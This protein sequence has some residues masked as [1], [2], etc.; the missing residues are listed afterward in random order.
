[1]HIEFDSSEYRDL[2]DILHLADV[3]MT[4][5][6]KGDD[7]RTARH[8]ALIQKL[9]AQAKNA[10]LD[11]LMTFNKDLGTYVPTHDF[12]HT[13]LAHAVLD[14]FANHLFWDHL[15][16]RLT[17]RDASQL[18]GGFERLQAMEPGDRQRLEGAI[19]QRYAEEFTANDVANLRLIEPLAS[20]G[21]MPAKTSD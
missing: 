8:R 1:M 14:D 20:A 13:T 2:L 19:R 16:N 4:G 9:Y 3:V 15:I 6:R 5:H 17:E 21:G 7:P 11:N 12:E 18:I 10:G